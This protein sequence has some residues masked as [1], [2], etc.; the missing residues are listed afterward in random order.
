MQAESL[1][2]DDIHLLSHAAMLA[3]V[4]LYN[5]TFL[6]DQEDQVKIP[7]FLLKVSVSGLVLVS[8]F[9]HQFGYEEF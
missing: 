1:Q 7:T 9:C 2:N 5:C 4:F 3:F 8:R 6:V